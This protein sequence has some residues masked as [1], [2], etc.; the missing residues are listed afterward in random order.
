MTVTSA[1]TDGAGTDISGAGGTAF[2][3]AETGR[4]TVTNKVGTGTIFGVLKAS[5][6]EQ[7]F[8]FDTQFNNGLIVVTAA[9]SK[10]TV[11]YD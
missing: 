2:M 6:A 5:I 10:L 7:T 11:S 9:A 3:D 4:G 1:V 8:T